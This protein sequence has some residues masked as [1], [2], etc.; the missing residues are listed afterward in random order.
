MP[1]TI[2]RSHS[3][4]AK[5]VTTAYSPP[6]PP[7][8]RPPGKDDTSGYWAAFSL[9]L[10]EEPMVIVPLDPHDYKLAWCA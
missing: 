3:N 8:R 4:G 1:T 9:L 2:E 6:S 5:P 10:G 7:P